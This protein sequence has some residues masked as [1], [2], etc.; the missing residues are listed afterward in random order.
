MQKVVRRAALARK[1]SQRKAKLASEKER[2]ELWKARFNEKTQF[3]R[4]LLDETKAER[5][6]RREDWMRGPLAPKRDSGTRLGT[7]GTIPAQRMH[8][9]KVFEEEKRKF[10]NIIPEDRVCLMKGKD[11]G[12]IGKVT[13][14]DEESLS[15]TVEGLN[16]V[17]SSATKQLPPPILLSFLTCYSMHSTTWSSL[18]S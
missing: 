18:N 13:A 3:N 2:H 1:Q 7:Y 17:S 6:T 12:K 8:L 16:T 9:P 4:S 10:I 15:V 14:V 5:L 11:K